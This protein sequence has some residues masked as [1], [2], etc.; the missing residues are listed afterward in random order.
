MLVRAGDVELNPG[1]RQGTIDSALQ[2]MELVLLAKDVPG[3]YYSELSVGLGFSLIEGQNVLTKHLLDIPGASIELFGRWKLKQRDG[4][5]CRAALGEILKETDMDALQT[6]LLEGHMGSRR[7]LTQEE[8]AQCSRD[9]KAFYR[10]ELCKINTDPLDFT[11]FREFEQIYINLEL[12]RN[13]TGDDK[14]KELEYDHL[15]IEKINGTFSKR[16][17]IEGEGGAGKTTF[18]S[19]IAWDWTNDCNAFKQFEWVIVIPMRDIGNFQTVGKIAKTYLSDGNPVQA[20]QIDDYISSEPSKVLLIFDGLDEY[21]RDIFKDESHFGNI[22]R[23][24]KFK[25]STVLITSRPWKAKQLKEHK[26]LSTI[27]TYIGVEGF[28]DKNVSSYIRKYFGDDDLSSTGLINF[29]EENDVIKE[30]MAPYPIFILML[31][32]L[33]R[34]SSKERR[35]LIRKLKTFSQLFRQMIE[36]LKEHLI[37]KCCDNSSGITIDDKTINIHLIE[38]GKIAFSGLLERQLTFSDDMFVTC[39][40]AMIICSKIGILSRKKQVVQRLSR[41]S[42]KIPSVTYDISFPHKL[43]QEYVAALFLASLYESNFDEFT[44]NFDL[45]LQHDVYEYEY[46]VY[47]TSSQRKDVAS[48]IIDR[49]NDECD[50][51]FLVEIAFESYDANCAR[52][53][54]R[55]LFEKEKSLLIDDDMPA[56][57]VSGYMFVLEQHHVVCATLFFTYRLYNTID[58]ALQDMEL[59][60]FAKDVPGNYY[61]ELSVGLGFSLMGARMS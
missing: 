38:I 54:G 9:F 58:S 43:F 41:S 4:T 61:S 55:L 25:D 30:N 60:L 26:K 52:V 39:E 59:V 57:L 53:V 22:V 16:F 33:W 18:C 29:I 31:C 37:A 36:F 35:I 51:D 44:R 7:K 19:K 48:Y 27:Y 2:D 1:P 56:H 32:I 11:L 46:L 13:K 3:N 28:S 20:S 40:N 47:F 8:V 23:C 24:K 15:L 10:S 50:R 14:K 17:L 12:L 42:S 5:D 45:I 21:N 49:I 34:E 6:K